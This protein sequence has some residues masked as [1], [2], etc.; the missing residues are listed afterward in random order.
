MKN[1]V[2][3]FVL[4]LS[5]QISKAQ[6]LDNFLQSVV[7]KGGVNYT[8]IKSEKQEELKQLIDQLNK[9]ITND[10]K[11]AAYINLYNLLVIDQV[12][13]NYPTT[14]PTSIAGFF[15]ANKVLVGDKKMTLNDLENNIIRPSYKDPR[16]HFALVCGAK[17]CPP[18][19]NFAYSKAKLDSQLT[20]VTAWAINDSSF[21]KTD[22][23]GNIKISEIFKWY[24]DDF[25]GTSKN[26]KSF[27]N[28]YKTQKI[29]SFSYY[30]Y[31]WSLNDQKKSAANIATYTPSV[32]LKKGQ[33]EIVMFNNMY[34][35]TGSFG[36]NGKKSTGDTRNT[37]NTTMMTFNYGA[38]KSARFNIGL[39]VNLRSV[40]NDAATSNAISIFKYEQNNNNRTTISTIGP[41]IKWNP[42][43]SI[44]KF[45]M[46]STF[47]IPV[48]KNLQSN[49]WLDWQRY[50]SWTQFFYDKTFGTKYQ[51]FT[52]LAAWV[53][54]PEIGS[55][56]GL[57]NTSLETPISVFFSYFPT[58]KSTIYTQLQYWPVVSSLPNYF[59]Q[60]GIGGKYQLLKQ[61][62]IEASYTNFFAGINQGAGAT[63][64]FGLRFISK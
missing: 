18:I 46:Q 24:V 52:E 26:V 34:T 38:S 7:T 64:N 63:F 60:A 8:L 53:R 21:I 47:W 41:K 44:P 12:V 2:Y 13:K 15:D 3:L 45:S 27:I 32:L 49:P 56:E 37:W 11:K 59:A 50:T 62:Q 55:N 54:I 20:K 61:L 51:V 29:S 9:E 57:N 30:P 31:D 5:I 48:A 4:L 14:S 1:L 19:Q 10:P 33:F 35:Q 17:S 43:K 58:G 36:E 42:I 25:G 22:K 16:V 40:R 39:D 23:E 6:N 28:Q